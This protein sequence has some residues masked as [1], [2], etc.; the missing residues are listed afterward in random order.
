MEQLDPL[1]RVKKI[2]SRGRLHLYMAAEIIDLTQS[3]DDN[4]IDLVDSSDLED[5]EINDLKIQN[6]SSYY[7]RAFIP[8]IRSALDNYSE[9]ISDEEKSVFSS[10]MEQLNDSAQKLFIR[11][12]F[13]KDG[14]IRRDKLVYAD[15]SNVDLAIKQ[16]TSLT[17][18]TTDSGYLISEFV[19]LFTL[20]ELKFVAAKLFIKVTSSMQKEEIVKAILNSKTSSQQQQISFA[21][22]SGKMTLEKRKND[23]IELIRSVCGGSIIKICD[24]VRTA[25]DMAVTL[26]FMINNDGAAT[27]KESLSTAILAELNRVSYPKYKVNRKDP[28]FRTRSDYTE[29]F[30]ALELEKSLNDAEFE[31][32]ETHLQAYERGLLNC[33]RNGSYFLRR[34]SSGWVYTRIMNFIAAQLESSKE[35]QKAVDVYLLLLKQDVFCLGYRGRWWERCVL[36][37]SRHLKNPERALEL[38]REALQDSW[39]RTAALTSIKRRLKKLTKQLLQTD[40]SV[41]IDLGDE[42]VPEIVALHGIIQSG[43]VTGKKVKLCLDDDVLSMDSVENFVL[44]EFSKDNWTGV[45][46]ESSL[47]TTL[48]SLLFWDL[49]FE[50]DVSDVFLTPYQIAP[51][52]LNTD[53]FFLQRR[54]VLEERLKLI[55]ENFDAAVGILRKHHIKNHLVSCI[56]VNWKEYSGEEGLHILVKV[57]TGIGGMALAL[58]LRQFCEDYRHNRSGMPDLILWRNPNCTENSQ[59]IDHANGV[60]FAEVKSP[61]DR[62]SDGQ[63]H[64]FSVLKSA[65]LRAILVKVHDQNNKIADI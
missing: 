58:I 19:N 7:Q 47:F 53:S 44:Q 40:E 51:L 65:G 17:L 41:S 33:D 39:L 54:P 2:F 61:N 13:R 52:D 50:T 37:T 16:L 30:E 22:N 62:L 25:I 23:K 14:W 31:Y 1:C 43:N 9:I 4:I 36:N 28:I 24:N 59:I 6:N 45:H 26:H 63:R 29:Y 8:I 21:P 11:L 34:Y 35:Y 20:A 46:C 32:D 27:S 38:C 5:V 12:F 18:C 10:I 60:L 48:F 49:L 57:A 42:D 56:G 55:E 15:V 64:W 3:I